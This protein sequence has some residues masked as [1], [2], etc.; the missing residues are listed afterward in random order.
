MNGPNPV[1]TSARKK[2]NQSSPRRLRADACGGSL[3]P[4]CGGTKDSAGFARGWP[5]SS[6][7][8]PIPRGWAY[9][10]FLRLPSSIRQR[11]QSAR[12][13]EH[14]DGLFL[15]V[16]GRGFHL[17]ARELRRNEIGRAAIE[18]QRV[19]IDSN[20]AAADP[21]KTPEIDH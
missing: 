18:V 20:L 17:I 4:A 9:R 21:E 19:P 7:G 3:A 8:P 6:T 12:R 14:D 15:L 5:P 11:L 16:F 1:C 13:A 10:L 2:M